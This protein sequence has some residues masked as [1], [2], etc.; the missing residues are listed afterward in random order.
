MM[1]RVRFV[2]ILVM[3]DL[4]VDT[5]AQRKAYRLFRKYLVKDGY[6]M[7]QESV[8][9]KLSVDDAHA[10]SAIAR[11]R[12]HRPSDGLVQVLRITEKQ[13]AAMETIVGE[14]RESEEIDTLDGFVVI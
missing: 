6:L 4:P 7:V 13:F 12:K 2:R 3:F 5:A 1:E 11:L 14:R 8:Y 10:K 9:A